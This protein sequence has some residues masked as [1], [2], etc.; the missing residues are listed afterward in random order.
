MV[1]VCRRGAALLLGCLLLAGG[2]GAQTLTGTVSGRVT[3]EQGGVLPGATVTVTGRTGSQARPTDPRGEYR[4]PA[5]APG[6]YAVR[7][8]LQGFRTRAQDAIEIGAG[9]TLEVNLALAVGDLS[10]TVEVVG[11]RAIIDTSSTATDSTLSQDLLF[12]M[13][14]SHA[15]PAA[16]ILQYTPGV[17]GGSALGGSSNTGNAL[18]LDGVDTRDPASGAAWPFYDYNIIQEVQAVGLGQPA[19]YGGYTGT[20]INTITKSG[21]NR[22][23]FLGEYRYTNDSRW[24]F[25]DNTRPSLVAQNRNLASP[26]RVLRLNDYTVQLGGPVKKDRLFF[27]AS[28]QRYEVHRKTVGPIGSEVS[29]RFNVKLTFQPTPADQVTASFQYDQFNFRGSTGWIPAY[30]VTSQ[31]QTLDGDSPEYIWSAQYRRVFN[32]STFLEAKFGGYTGYVSLIPASPK[33]MHFDIGTNAYSGGAGYSQ[34]SD[35]SRNQVNVVLSKYAEWAGA[36]TF[37]FGVEIERSRSR[38]RSQLSG[39]GVYFLDYF[40]TPYRAYGYS[41]DLRA[42]NDRESY[43]AQDQW[44]IAGRLTAN[45]GVRLDKIRGAALSTGQRLYDTL[46]TGPRLGAAWDVTGKGTSVLKAS[47]GRLYESAMTYAWISAVPGWSDMVTY[48]VGPNWGTLTEYDRV[49]ATMKYSVDGGIR[50]PRVE[51]VSV[52]WEQALGGTVRMTATGVWRDWHNFVNSVLVDG[53]WTSAT[54]TLPPWA[55]P[56]TNP[57]AGTATVPIYRW[58][59]RSD[60]PKFLI[61]NTDSVDYVV[62]GRT[63][64]GAGTRSYRAL[65]LLV[66]RRLK[67]R[68]QAQGSWVVSKT[69]GTVSNNAYAGIMGGQ[70]ETPNR[71]LTNAGGPA[72]YDSRHV[73]RLF[74]GY[75]VPRIELSVNAIWSYQSGLPYA[76]VVNVGTGSTRWS[77]PFAVNVL[78]RGTFRTE[79][80]TRT[81]LR[82]E[83]VLRSGIHRFGVYAD[84]E[85]PFNRSTVLTNSGRY[86]SAQLTDDQ[87][88]QF[89]VWFNGPLTQ[90]EGRQI[91]LGARWTF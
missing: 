27:F 19:E 20:V 83:K 58:A 23:A 24:L 90:L 8:E 88:Q 50:H 47:Y 7:A 61:R 51:E 38:D 65:M 56:G 63:V 73:V 26:A 76:P 11:E 17:V 3:D 6:V 70:F 13:P 29:P 15:Q 34:R 45:L 49:P 12:S 1:M 21:G 4:F 10:E 84:V 68:W 66:E 75:Q 44:K 87:G 54:Y 62:D 30:A 67:N 35:R 69:A 55:G 78:P 85:N 32:P 81:S 37:K 22:F 36:H 14:M 16:N 72:S 40:G 28:T 82:V 59:N 42:G 57:I 52:A 31:D 74:A 91:T 79:G 80:C 64:T 5:L 46:S 9:R 25:G 53:R 48:D 18:L 86:P 71:I 39:A 60:A 41:Y 77:S 33:E 2:A 89:P 43:Y